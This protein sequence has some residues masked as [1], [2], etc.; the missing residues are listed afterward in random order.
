MLIQTS[1][2]MD[3]DCF[4]IYSVDWQQSH[5]SWHHRVCCCYI[6]VLGLS[7]DLECRSEMCCMQLAGNTGRKNDTKK[8][9]SRHH[10]M[11]LLG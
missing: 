9:P 4:L 10:C 5:D 2:V 1:N 11:T 6:T 3:H 8:S 7:A